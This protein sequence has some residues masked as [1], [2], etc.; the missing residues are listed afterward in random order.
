MR[1]HRGFTLIELLVVFALLALLVGLVPVAFERLRE[2]AQYRQTVRGMI[3]D[4]RQ[5]RQ[6][7]MAEGTEVRFHV[8]LA[9]RT[10]GLDGR[11]AQEVPEPLQLRATV[12]AIE[13][14]DGQAASIRFLPR[15]GATGGS[16]DVLRP[17]GSG[18]RLTVDW[19]SGAIEQSAIQP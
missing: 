19:L 9:A 8:D 11:P 12:A 15:G 14:A 7:A 17:S 3:S 2:S 16:I 6:R 1:A 18:V 4:M 5:G 13:M 10:F